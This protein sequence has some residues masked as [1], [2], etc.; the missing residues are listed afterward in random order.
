M[1]SSTR[2][3]VPSAADAGEGH[4]R[5]QHCGSSGASPQG[6]ALR[7]LD[8]ILSAHVLVLSRFILDE[9]ERVL[10]YPRLQARYRIT[11]S[12]VARFTEK[13]ADVAHMVEPVI[14][15]PIVLSDPD[16]DAVLYKAA[17]GRADV[18]CTR[19][20]RQFDVPEV[21]SFCAAQS[22]RVLTDLQVLRELLE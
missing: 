20:I 3:S 5:L 4:T 11:A 8:L 21:H 17:A 14:A 13:L 22:I 9:V 1:R 19:N 12:E 7:L 15:R 6:P 18:L 16:D 2:Q 10:L